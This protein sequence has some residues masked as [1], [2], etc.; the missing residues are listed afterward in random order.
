MSTFNLPLHPL[1]VVH[2]LNDLKTV[3]WVILPLVFV[4]W[5]ACNPGPL[6]AVHDLND[7]KTVVWVILPLAFVRWPACNPGPSEA[8][9]DLNDL[10]T[11]VWV[12]NPVRGWGDVGLF[13]PP[14]GAG[15]KRRRL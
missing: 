4:R 10:K 5:A 14:A 13:G 3:V 2:D 9:H 12:I 6:G 8:V 11:V 15:R 1:G 7:L